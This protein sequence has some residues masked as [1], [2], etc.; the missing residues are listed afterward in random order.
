[1]LD[2]MTWYTAQRKEYVCW[3]DRSNHRVGIQQESGLEIRNR[4]LDEFRYLGNV[5]TANCRGDKYIE[6]QFRGQN[7]GQEVFLVKKETH[8][9]VLLMALDTPARV[10]HLR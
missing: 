1:M 8:S 9:N 4:V 2:L 7:A 10:W 3:Y 5:M 6:N